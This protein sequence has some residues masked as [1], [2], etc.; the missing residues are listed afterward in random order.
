[1]FSFGLFGCS[2]RRKIHSEKSIE[3][4]REKKKLFTFLIT[5]T[6]HLLLQVRSLVAFGIRSF[7]LLYPWMNTHTHT[8]SLSLSLSLSLTHTHTCIQVLIEHTD[9]NN[10]T[11][12][13]QTHRL[14]QHTHTHIQTHKERTFSFSFCIKLHPIL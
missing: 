13:P 11:H 9:M 4:Q 8:H 12:K 7:S 10:K 1:M 2:G 14:A 5:L 6:P 3:R